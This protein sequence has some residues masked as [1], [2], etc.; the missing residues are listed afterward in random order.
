LPEWLADKAGDIA[1]AAGIA[2]VV[3]DSIEEP[4][5]I[6]D[7]ELEGSTFTAAETEAPD[8]PTDMD[9]G[10][11]EAIPSIEE[12]LPDWLSDIEGVEEMPEIESESPSSSVDESR[13]VPDWLRDSKESL[14]ITDEVAETEPVE[15]HPFAVD[16]DLFEMDQLAD[17][18]SD[19]SQSEID[20]TQEKAGQVDGLEPAELPGWLAAMRPVESTAPDGAGLEK[21][22]PM[23]NSGPLAGLYGVLAAEPDIARLKKPPVYSSKLQITDAQQSHATVLQE[24]LE[25][26]SQS[27]ELPVA[28]LLSSQRVFRVALSAILLVI[29]FI[30]VFAGSEI[31]MMPSPGN[32]PSGVEQTRNLVNS[33]TTDDTALI[34]FDYEPG[35][36]GEMEAASA[37][38]VDH[39]MLKGAKL[40]L[41][42]TSP[43]GPV[44]AEHF[45]SNVQG[46]HGYVSGNQYVN[47]GYIP[48]GVT[49]LGAFARNPRLVSPDSLDGVPAWETA[50]LQNIKWVDDFALVVLITD[51]PNTA[52][53]WVEQ[54]NPE[55]GAVPMVALVS[56]QAEPMV[57]P[58]F[59]NQQDQI[60]G[61][62]SGL[63]GGAA[64][65]VMTRSNVARTYWDAF[66]IVL[67]VA[68]SAILIGG[69]IAVISSILAQ[70]KESEGESG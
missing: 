58:Y 10:D 24:L 13:A 45:V 66:N 18:I 12:N 70:R 54:V 47:L 1:L 8:W 40:A 56:A 2:K 35:L 17:W 6:E 9:E 46:T 48:G 53:A 20:P 26:E 19:E 15:A 38:V 55:L 36:S 50:P 31:T 28:P 67:I 11:G 34:A 39:V 63:T 5:L 29:A 51:N 42:S 43:T 33:L 61:L 62:V 32:I 37:A 3:G 21:R 59:N 65:E 68:V 23:E 52:R 41:L 27:Q 14:P 25:A 44:L 49:G 7:A 22:G 4:N 69:F 57:R 60:D 16:E 64:Y 30:A